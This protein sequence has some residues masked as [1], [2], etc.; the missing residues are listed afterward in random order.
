[1]TLS[2][3]S[4]ELD[5]DDAVAGVLVL[6]G[7]FLELGEP[8]TVPGRRTVSV[9]GLC[10]F[11][12]DLVLGSLAQTPRHSS[13]SG[14]AQQPIG[15]VPGDHLGERRPVH[16]GQNDDSQV[17]IGKEGRR[18]DETVDRSAVMHAAMAAII[19]DPPAQCIPGRC[20][21]LAFLRARR[22]SCA[23]FGCRSST[24]V[25]KICLPSILPLCV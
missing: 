5:L 4:R 3:P 9:L 24:A 14:Q 18:G 22:S 6:A 16:V 13:R 19:V 25:L 23:A 21:L 11:G 12:G 8:E 2:L 10:L 20:D 7:V 17:V 1:M 15:R